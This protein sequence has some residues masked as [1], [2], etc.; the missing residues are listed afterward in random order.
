M[1]GGT[2]LDPILVV[3]LLRAR[4]I[5]QCDSFGSKVST[6][7]CEIHLQLTPSMNARDVDCH[8]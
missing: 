3:Q 6:K 8:L 2:D 7:H 5:P 1:N 4:L